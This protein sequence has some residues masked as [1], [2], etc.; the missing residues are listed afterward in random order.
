MDRMDREQEVTTLRPERFAD[1]DTMGE[2]ANGINVF[3]YQ[4]TP[5]HAWD[6]TDLPTQRQDG[7]GSLPELVG[8]TY[9]APALTC[10]RHEVVAMRPRV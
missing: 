1:A 2:A 7:A 3:P 4:V 8:E 10:H 6:L 5:N 9:G